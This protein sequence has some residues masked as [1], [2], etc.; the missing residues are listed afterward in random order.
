MVTVSPRGNEPKVNRY[1]AV[2]LADD[3]VAGWSGGADGIVCAVTIA[4][5]ALGENGRDPVP[6]WLGRDVDR[7]EVAERP[8]QFAA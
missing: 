7:C 2:E 4:A 5:T 6:R 3:Q 8:A 1:V